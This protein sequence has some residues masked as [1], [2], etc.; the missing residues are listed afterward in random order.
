MRCLLLRLTPA[1]LLHELGS[2]RALDNARREH[3]EVARTTAIVDA[4]A[5]RLDAAS[6]RRA[7][8]RRLIATE[9]AST[10]SIVAAYA[11]GPCT[12]SSRISSPRSSRV[13]VRVP[14]RGPGQRP[15]PWP[16]DPRREPPFVPRLDLHPARRAP[17]GDVRGQGRVLRRRRRPRG[18]SGAAGRSRSGAR[19]AARASARSRRRPRCSARGRCVRRSIPR[20][21]ARATASST[22]VTPASPGSRCGC[23]VADRSGRPR[24]HRRGAAGRLAAAEAVPP[25]DDPLRRADRSRALRRS[26][27][28]PHG[29]ARAHRR[30]D[31]RDRRSSRATST[32]TRTRRSRPRTSRP[33]PRTS[34]ASPTPARPVI[35]GVVA[36]ARRLEP[37]S[38]GPVA[39][40]LDARGARPRCGPRARRRP[41]PGVNDASALQRAFDLGRRGPDAFGD[42]GEER[43]AE[44]GRLLDRGAAHGHAEHV[45]LELAQQVHHR[46]AAVDAHLGEA[47]V[48][49]ARGDR[50]DHVGGLERHRLDDGAG[51]MRAR[52]AAGDA[53]D[54]AR[55]RTGPTTASRAR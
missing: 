21:R 33:K 47:P 3:E 12:G 10:A 27:A 39:R 49:L 9:P 26:R 15:E 31:V 8:S 24:R 41:S 23:N 14:G 55:A 2:G 1:N 6:T 40:P 52:R 19:A 43:G 54:R 36:R 16:G 53:D 34:P 46:R 51:E 28:R 11:D 18:S 32:S 50:V 35:R 38:R 20:A 45:G 13:F 7:A 22:A 29:A 4:L 17:A 37:S 44:R 30:S 48:P 25:G 5:G 42:A